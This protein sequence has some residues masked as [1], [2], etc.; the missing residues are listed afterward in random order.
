MP[1]CNIKHLNRPSSLQFRGAIEIAENG[2]EGVHCWSVIR[3]RGRYLAQ[4]DGRISRP[5]EFFQLL[6]RNARNR[7]RVYRMT[8]VKKSHQK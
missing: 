8:F 2:K 7:R 4:S 5:P 6:L 3:V 1:E